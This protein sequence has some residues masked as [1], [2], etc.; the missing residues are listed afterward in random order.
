MSKQPFLPLFFG[1]LLA[2]TAA[3]DGEERAFYILLLAYQ[4]TSGPLPK[5]PKRI[6]RMCQYEWKKFSA[7]WGMVGAKFV[8]QDDGL[9]NLRLEEH[10]EKSE[11]ISK[12]NEERARNAASKRWKDASSN[13]PSTSSSDAPSNAQRSAAPDAIHPIPSHTPELKPRIKPHEVSHRNATPPEFDEIRRL[14]PKRG[15]G[16]RWPAAEKAYIARL[17]E[18]HTHA[19]MIAGVR[20]YADFNTAAGK[21]GT[22]FVQMASTFF[23]PNKSFLEP[24]T[25]PK[26]PPDT[27]QLSTVERVRL[28][29][30][31]G[32]KHDER[33]V[34]EQNGKNI[35][36]LDSLDGDVR[37]PV[38]S[39]LRRLGS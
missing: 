14:Y 20:R 28:A 11:R 34:S 12:Q 16:Q 5:D 18:G 7:L 27:R 30:G 6:A 38:H 15:G 13:A 36:D 10:R 1:D 24:W 4:W 21:T 35:F 23:G 32:A 2:S 25:P 9:V 39:G 8:E 19:E 31:N 17:A 22:E 29:N 26:P 33:V 3:W 37:Q